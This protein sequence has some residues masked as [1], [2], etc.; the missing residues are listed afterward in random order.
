MDRTKFEKTVHAKDIPEKCEL[1]Y[2][3]KPKYDSVTIMSTKVFICQKC[4][5]KYGVG[6]GP[7]KG[8]KL[9]VIK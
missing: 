7:G 5:D 1:C 9:I 4:F 8:Q 6:L 3:H 2:R